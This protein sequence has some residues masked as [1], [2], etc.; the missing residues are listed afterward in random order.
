VCKK[1]AEIIDISGI[2]SKKQKR[3]V[4]DGCDLACFG[5]IVK[6]IFS[7][8]EIFLI[9]SGEGPAAGRRRLSDAE[10]FRFALKGDGDQESQSDNLIYSDDNK[11]SISGW[12]QRLDNL[13]M[14]DEPGYVSDWEPKTALDAEQTASVPAAAMRPR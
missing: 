4:V 12:F 10:G 14:Q 5:T 6:S 9:G 13:R 11:V 7:E 1:R 3:V 2:L 8:R